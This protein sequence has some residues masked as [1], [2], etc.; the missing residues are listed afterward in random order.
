M[1]SCVWFYV[2]FQLHILLAFH[3]AFFFVEISMYAYTRY[4]GNVSRELR[5]R[6]PAGLGFLET[7]G[8][9]VVYLPIYPY[10]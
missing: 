3:P 2:R 9:Q 7:T 4:V 6:D 5:S 8:S 1:D 10:K